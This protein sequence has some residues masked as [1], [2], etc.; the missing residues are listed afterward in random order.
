[1]TVKFIA[2]PFTIQIMGVKI[3]ENLGF[4]SPLPKVEIFLFFFLFIFKLKI[5]LP[6]PEGFEPQIFSNFPAHDLNFQG[7]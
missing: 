2:S 1:M 6:D 4:K 7:K 3:T 5:D